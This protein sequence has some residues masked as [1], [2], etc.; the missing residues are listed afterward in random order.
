MARAKKSLGQNFLVDLNIQRKIVDALEP[1]SADTV[2]EI[3][4]GRGALTR[5]LADRVG[6]LA[7]IELDDALADQLRREFARNPHVRVIHGDALALDVRS[8]TD[9]PGALKIVGNIPYNITTPLLFWALDPRALPAVIVMMIQ[10]EVAD[11]ILAPPGDKTYGALSVGVRTVAD[12]ERLFNVSRGAFKPVPDVESTVIR[13]V[14]KRPAPLDAAEAADLRFF[15]RTAFSWRR[16]QLQKILR[17]GAGYGLDPGQ[18]TQIEQSLGVEL[19]ARPETLSP[20]QFIA[21]SKE[22]RRMGFPTVPTDIVPEA[23]E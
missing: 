23:D 12:V 17:S 20:D 2:L 9:Q 8:V 10:K 14:P 1:S 19:S 18:V 22:L 5:H 3:G 6:R 11:R 4:P 7:V 21:L 16:K 15:T 13:I